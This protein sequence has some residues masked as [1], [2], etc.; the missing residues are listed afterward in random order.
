MSSGGLEEA[1]SVSSTLIICKLSWTRGKIYSE[2]PTGNPALQARG[3]FNW[4]LTATVQ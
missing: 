1:G 2:E 4:P 3:V